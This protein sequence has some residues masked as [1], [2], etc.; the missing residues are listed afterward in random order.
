MKMMLC[1][2]VVKCVKDGWTMGE[3]GSAARWSQTNR[4]MTYEG[5]A[6]P[7]CYVSNPDFSG[8]IECSPPKPKGKRLSELTTGTWHMVVGGGKVECE[9]L[10]PEL[11]WS[12]YFGSALIIPIAALTASCW[13]ASEDDAR[14]NPLIVEVK[15]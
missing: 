12:T 10:G 1:E 13:Y 6:T 9:V 11:I 4:C 14:A 7:V 2:A 15:S 3:G 8:E 5:E